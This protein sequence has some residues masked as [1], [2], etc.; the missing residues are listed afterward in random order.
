[1]TMMIMMMQVKIFKVNRIFKKNNNFAI[2]NTQKDTLF[3]SHAFVKGVC[4]YML[5]IIANGFLF[6]K[7]A[8]R[9][10]FLG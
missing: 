4:F 7:N 3:E 8:N 1:M 6:I 10:L 5:I 9:V 2:Q